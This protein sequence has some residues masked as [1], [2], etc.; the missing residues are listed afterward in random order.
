MAELPRVLAYAE[1]RLPR[2]ERGILQ[3]DCLPFCELV[4]ATMP[5]ATMRRFWTISTAISTGCRELAVVLHR[6]A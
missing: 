4:T 2:A 1:F 6:P 5:A 3:V